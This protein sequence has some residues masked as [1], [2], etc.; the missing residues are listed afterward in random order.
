MSIFATITT[1]VNF[2]YT[3]YENMVF[4]DN[5]LV[6]NKQVFENFS[7]SQKITFRKKKEHVACM[8]DA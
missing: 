5:T 4:P 6:R 3:Y 2:Q 1:H 8:I 7:L